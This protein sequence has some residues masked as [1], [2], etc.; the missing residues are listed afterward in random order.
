[1]LKFTIRRTLSAAIVE[2]TLWSPFE[3]I[4]LIVS[5]TFNSINR[6]GSEIKEDYDTFI[7]NKKESTKEKAGK[8]TDIIKNLISGN[9][10]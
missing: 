9:S 5:F 2:D 1:M 10:A 6:H 4:R 7:R 3:I 8:T